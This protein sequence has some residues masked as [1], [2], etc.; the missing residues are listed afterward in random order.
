[1]KKA[2]IRLFALLM[3]VLLAAPVLAQS[4]RAAEV[5]RSQKQQAL[6]DSMDLS[7]FDGTMNQAASD[8]TALKPL[9]IFSA[10]IQ[11]GSQSAI[12][13]AFLVESGGKQ[14]IV[15]DAIL[16]NDF[17]SGVSITLRTSSNNYSRS[18]SY[19]GGDDMFCYLS[20]S[21][22]EL[23]APLPITD[24]IPKTG[25]AYIENTD[26]DGTVCTGLAWLEL[27]LSGMNQGTYCGEPAY[28]HE[29][30]KMDTLLIGA[31]VLYPGKYEV[32]G[33]ASDNEGKLAV[34]S[35][36]NWEFPSAYAMGDSDGTSSGGGSAA[37]ETVGMSDGDGTDAGG[38]K[39]SDSGLPWL[40]IIAVAGALGYMIYRSNTRKKNAAPREGTVPLDKVEVPAEFGSGTVGDV[41]PVQEDYGHTVPNDNGSTTPTRSVSGYYL[42]CLSGPLAGQTFDIPLGGALT[43]GRSAQ[44]DVHLPENTPG[45]SG[46]HCSASLAIDGVALRDLASTYGT[47]LGTNQRLEP[48]RDYDLRVGDTVTLAKGGPSFRLEMHGAAVEEFGPGVRD[49]AGRTYRAD[50]GGRISFGRSP[51][52]L[53]RFP[54]SDQSVSGRHC[55]LYREAGKLYLMDLDS[56]NGTFFSE[57]ER[58]KPNVP[59]RIRKGMAFFLTNPKNT[60]VVTEE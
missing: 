56:T 46:R 42:R 54:R 25:Y 35:F 12:C 55:V 36:L 1:M 41:P 19:L 44:C 6:L 11:K 37:T 7:G 8:D 59:Y 47:F 52:N 38:E 13:A 27:D 20:A 29:E 32:F 34:F 24:D 48:D 21:G 26:E 53:V 45:V 49:L 57:K 22:M 15:T 40:V 4:V 23:F 2:T 18:A 43:I 16:T 51:D 14:Y 50:A 58:L 3:A 30:L 5:S 39:S 60:F 33:I 9:G 10:L 31:P 28:V 17:E